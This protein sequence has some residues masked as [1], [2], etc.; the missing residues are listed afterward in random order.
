MPQSLRPSLV[1]LVA[2]ALL[3]G[4][5]AYA[6]WPRMQSVPLPVPADSREVV[7]LYAATNTAAWERFVSAMSTAVKR[8]QN[9]QPEL[10]L[11]P[12]DDRRAFPRETTAVPEVTLAAEGKGKLLFRWYKLTSEWKTDRWVEALLRREPPPLAIIGGSSSDPAIELANALEA[13]RVAARLDAAPLLLL[14]TA[15]ASEGRRHRDQLPQPLTS[16]YPGRTYRFG[17]T[18]KQMAEALTRFLYCQDGLRPDAD[19]VYMTFWEDDRYSLDLTEQ[20]LAALS[21]P[22]EMRAAA[23]DWAWAAGRV[24]G[25]FPLDLSGA[26]WRR[27]AT[28][29]P[30]EPICC[31]VG[32]FS[33]PNR[34]EADAARNLLDKFSR[35]P[36]Q[37]PPLILPAG[38]SQAARRFLRGLVRA[39]PAEARRLVVV[40][41]DGLAFNVIYRDRNVTWPIQDLPF[42]LVF[43]CHRN[44]VDPI[45]FCA[46]E[47]A[48]AGSSSAGQREPTGTEDLLLFVDIV[49]VI[50]QAAFA[51]DEV[52]ASGDELGRSL[53]RA[54]W[55]K[56]GSDGRARFGRDGAPLFDE[57][58]NRSSGTGG[59]VVW[60]H[61]A[62][63]GRRRL[64]RAQISVWSWQAGED[65]QDTTGWGGH[66]RASRQPLRVEYD[67]PHGG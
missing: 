45:H 39:S 25:A 64:P 47:E 66:W 16:L 52:S 21:R 59:H 18:N 58:G 7:W 49:E 32:S 51:G 4:A 35:H 57:R 36:A 48:D 54:R 53:R 27:L 22:V 63:E 11:L 60:L 65:S 20:L 5:A 44:P 67:V 37:R 46:E 42:D 55:Q 24:T 19:P 30:S 12:L 10:G 50:T 34:W 14:T 61:P 13:E 23:R 6:L 15:T 62:I 38:S 56:I 43:F 26:Y 40:T 2:C 9:E 17:F 29:P 31:S 33:Q 41:G 8:L 3:L 1:L 28:W